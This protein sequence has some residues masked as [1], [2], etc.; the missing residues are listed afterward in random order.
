MNLCGACGLDFGSVTAF[1][2]HRVGTHEY[3]YREGLY[4]EPE[5][6]DGRRCLDESELAALTDRHG[7]KLF[8]RNARGRF[9]LARSLKI[10]SEGLS[11]GLSIPDGPSEGVEAA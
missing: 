9:S 8:G 4:M 11:V 6:A 7:A 2:L 3:T 5:R 10:A 1:D